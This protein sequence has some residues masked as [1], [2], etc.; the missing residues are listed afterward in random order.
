MAPG[1]RS[2]LATM[3]GNFMSNI[4][5]FDQMNILADRLE[6]RSRDMELSS[7]MDAQFAAD[8]VLVAEILRSIAP[9]MQ[10]GGRKARQAADPAVNGRRRS[11]TIDGEVAQQ[12][13]ARWGPPFGALARQ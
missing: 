13:L 7:S 6:A 9:L 4:T 5:T 12:S 10:N 11:G 1:V 3:V 8:L 2:G